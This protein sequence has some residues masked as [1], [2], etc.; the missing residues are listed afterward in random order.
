MYPILILV[1]STKLF[2][3]H[4]R[5]DQ[6]VRSLQNGTHPKAPEDKLV[7]VLNNLDY[8]I[9]TMID[10]FAMRMS[11]IVRDGER[12]LAGLQPIAVSEEK[13]ET[14]PKEAVEP[15]EPKVSILPISSG[16][17]ERELRPEDVILGK[18]SEQVEKMGQQAQHV[19]ERTEL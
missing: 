14:D 16:K 7:P 10:G 8:E 6:L 4:E 11:V 17:S 13:D 12:W 3:A 18:S 9:Q 2:L 1:W 5:F 15:V 19:L